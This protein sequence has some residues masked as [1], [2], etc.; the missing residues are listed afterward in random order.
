MN[1]FIMQAFIEYLRQWE[2]VLMNI[3]TKEDKKRIHGILDYS[4]YL[5]VA[6]SR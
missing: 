1:S 5:R 2:A 3:I 4:K 6:K